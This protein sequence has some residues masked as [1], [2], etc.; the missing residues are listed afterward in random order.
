[1][2][3][4][5]GGVARRAVLAAIFVFSMLLSSTRWAR[6]A[7]W[8]SGATS[9]RRSS[10]ATSRPVLLIHDAVHQADDLEAGLAG[11][12]RGLHSHKNMAGSVAA[13]ATVMFFYF[14]LETKRR[15]DILLCAASAFFLVMT[16]SKSSLGLLPVALVAGVLYRIA[17]RNKLDRAIA[18]V[19]AVLLVIGLARRR[20]GRM[21]IHRPLPRRP[22]ELHRPLRDLG[23]G[24]VPISATIRCSA[25]ASARFGNT[26]VRSPIYHYVGPGWVAQI[27][28][29]HSGYLEMIVTHRRHRL[30]HRHGRPGGAAVPRVLEAGADATPTSTRMLFTLFVF[31]VLHNFMESD[32]IQVTVGAVGPDPA[33]HRPAARLRA[34]DARA[35]GRWR[36]ERRSSPS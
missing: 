36:H 23:G 11:A 31:D 19:A 9:W 22:A 4:R 30:R 7:R 29:G 26:G 15:S 6:R 1:M 3:R 10:W 13:A 20:L 14:A 5:A 28:E 24:G 27:G 8:R 16:R 18:A 17:W 25:P 33:D 2:E 35:R 34:G 21:G 32:F 12:W